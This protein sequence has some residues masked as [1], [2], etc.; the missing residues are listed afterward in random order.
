MQKTKFERLDNSKETV[1][2]FLEDGFM[3]A[4]FLIDPVLDKEMKKAK[5]DK[6]K[7]KILFSYIHLSTIH[8]RFVD[9]EFKQ[10]NKFK[11]TSAEIWRSKKMT[12]CTDYALVFCTL[13]RKYG[14]PT[15][16]FETVEEGCFKNIK[17]GKDVRKISGHAFCECLIDG[18][19]RLVDPTFSIVENDY[20]PEFVKLKLFHSV[21]GKK[22]FVP[23]L[24][25]I[26]T[27]TRRNI[28]E[29]NN[30]LKNIA[31]NGQSETTKIVPVSKEEIEKVND[32][33]SFNVENVSK[34]RSSL[35][36]EDENEKQ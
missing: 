25:E 29:H 22:H 23:V 15:T 8:P 1:D 2:K 18:K 5:S 16:F 26:D 33:T 13:A 20:N 14:L 9:G 27:G 30:M 17:A 35:E 36:K 28:L 11:R 34:S 12:G 10:G 7:V 24:R 21:A 3:T 6:D 4:Q 19:W 31:Q 32:K